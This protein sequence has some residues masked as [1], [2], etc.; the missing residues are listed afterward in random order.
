[1]HIL[2]RIVFVLFLAVASS[3]ADD[4]LLTVNFSDETPGAPPSVATVDAL[5]G[6]VFVSDAT[7]TPPDPFGPKDNLS[8]LLQKGPDDDRIPRVTWQVNQTDVGTLSF[9]FYPVDDANFP[10][11]LLTVFLFQD[12]L[13]QIG[14]SLS[15]G[16]EKI[17]VK[18]KEEGV[19][20]F[21]AVWQ[22]NSVNAVK[23][24]FAS[25]RTYVL[26]INGQPFPD[27]HTRF[28]FMSEIFGIDRVQFAI[29]DFQLRNSRV[30][31]DDLVLKKD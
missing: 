30:F 21:P 3:R 19:R 1:M 18:E 14:V 16:K 8:L 17:F 26:E 24:H 10:N 23:I 5:P 25:D 13:N 9:Q 6:G 15:F 22:T 29:A 20:T 2:L 31:I 11:S 12:N 7:S 4:P 27:E 28:Q